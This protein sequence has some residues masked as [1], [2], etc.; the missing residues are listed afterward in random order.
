MPTTPTRV[1]PDV[2]FSDAVE[3][4]LSRRDFTVN[5]MA[6]SLPNCASSIL[7]T[8]G[9]PRRRALAHPAVT[10]RSFSDDPLRM[11]RAARFHRGYGLVPDPALEAAGGP[12]AGP[13]GDRFR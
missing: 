9:G 8:C 6:L 7:T 4:D 1:I 13:L 2:E 11:L 10:R 3:V 12:P 5:A